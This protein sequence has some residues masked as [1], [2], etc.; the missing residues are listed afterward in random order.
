MVESAFATVAG[1]DGSKKA[2]KKK[3]SKR[4]RVEE[5]GRNRRKDSFDS[6]APLLSCRS[7]CHGTSVRHDFSVYHSR[8]KDV[9]H[10]QVDRQKFLS[11]T[12]AV[13]LNGEK[14]A[15]LARKL[16]LVV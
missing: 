7:H 13:C 9:S 12:C 14:K 16:N 4:E 8:K 3:Q 11:T 2:R 6:N 10:D 1:T 15:R 5:E